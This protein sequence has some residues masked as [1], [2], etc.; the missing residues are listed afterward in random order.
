MTCKRSGSIC[1][2]LTVGF[3][4]ATALG[5]TADP[6]DAS[7]V[8]EQK[9]S[10]LNGTTL[11]D[12]TCNAAARA[13]ILVAMG[14]AQTQV[15][16]NPGPL[17]ACLAD[18]F[19]GSAGASSPEKIVADL[20]TNLPTFFKCTA[21]SETNGNALGIVNVPGTGQA[22]GVNLE[23][24]FASG[25]SPEVVL[26]TVLHE[27]AHDHQY[28][29]QIS[30]FGGDLATTVPH[31]IARCATTLAEA[32]PGVPTGTARS[33]ISSQTE[34]GPVGGIGGTPQEIFCND[35]SAV[36]GISLLVGSSVNRLSFSC[37]GQPQLG[38]FLPPRVSFTAQV[39][40]T[41]GTATNHA[42]FASE[43]AIGATGTAGAL[44][45][46]IGVICAPTATVIAGGNP[47]TRVLQPLGS[48]TGT[49]WTRTCPPGMALRGA[50]VRAGGSVDRIRL[51]CRQ[52]ATP[53]AYR[54]REMAPFGGLDGDES[55]R[56]ENHHCPGSASLVSMRGTFGGEV[57]RIQ[58]SCA[59]VGITCT[60]FSTC[61]F[62]SLL[63]PTAPSISLST[64][65]G[66]GGDPYDENC[67]I[68]GTVMVGM[69]FRA[70]ARIDQ[71]QGMCAPLNQWLATAPAPIDVGTGQGAGGGGG[72]PGQ[73]MCPRGSILA[74]MRVGTV[75]GGGAVWSIPTI[76]DGRR[77]SRLTLVCRGPGA[78]V[79]A[80]TIP[81]PG[82]A[83][84]AVGV[85]GVRG[86]SI[87]DRAKVLNAA[88]TT[89]APIANIGAGTAGLGVSARTGNVWSARDVVLRNNAQVTGFV[90][91]IVGPVSTQ[92]PFMVTG[93][94][95][96]GPGASFTSPTLPALPSFPGGTFPPFTGAP[97]QALGVAPP[98][99]YGVV[100]L[101]A[102]SSVTL[103]SGTYFVDSIQMEPGSQ[104]TLDKTQGAIRIVVRTNI[105]FRGTWI[106]GGGLPGNSLVEFLGTNPVVVSTPFRGTLFAPRASI[107]VSNITAPHIGAFLGDSV[108]IF[109]DVTV[110]FT[111]F[112]GTI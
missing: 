1:S 106:D 27:I 4:L 23:P 12:T 93:A 18:G 30:R 34:L 99:T 79:P 39:G 69:K 82:P 17:T 54:D 109:E 87:N 86:V 44:V 62:G 45:N 64:E 110:H 111:P 6:N 72:T 55:P 57:N 104:V 91:A 59:Q 98:G 112:P 53:I 100:T 68:P 13:N 80:A 85:L 22:E 36:Q 21:S 52:I 63:A 65:G 16:V 40:G 88:G 15:A 94:V 24:S 92:G 20:A 8:V 76:D 28:G 42:C 33:S 7:D 48:T 35:D 14:I 107:L 19:L 43:V 3:L 66:F 11:F 56:E 5:C 25:S 10:A 70:G 83:V 38:A 61:T 2:V 108:T 95:V 49:P 37:L 90:D 9:T 84:N 60:S 47:T 74:G 96:A 32:P 50:H 102:G 101:N 81:G 29:H 26:G 46:S 41:G 78:N 75:S 89:P 103:R 67:S 58:P 73:R 105:I 51:E 77:V 71:L 97:G 31:Q